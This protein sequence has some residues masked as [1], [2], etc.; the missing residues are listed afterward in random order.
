MVEILHYEVANRN[1]TIGYVDI[2]VP[3]LKPT[4]VIF[5]RIAHVQSG[6]KKWFNLPTFSRE[7]IDGTPEYLKFCQFETEAFNAQLLESLNDKVKAFCK[8][9]GINQTETMSFEE[10]PETEEIPF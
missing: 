3:I 4:I 1:K 2:K 10:L 5:R 6:E 8:K 9:K 7:R